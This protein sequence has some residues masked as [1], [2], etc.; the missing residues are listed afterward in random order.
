[1]SKYHNEIAEY[2][3]IKPNPP[4]PVAYEEHTLED[5]KASI[6]KIMYPTND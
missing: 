4:V 5:I 2:H 6:K 3:G 1:M